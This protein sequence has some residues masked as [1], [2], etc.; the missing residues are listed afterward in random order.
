MAEA[1]AEGKGKKVVESSVTPEDVFGVIKR[2]L[3]KVGADLES[4]CE[5]VIQRILP[6]RRKSSSSSRPNSLYDA[7]GEWPILLEHIEM[8]SMKQR[9]LGR[10]HQFVACQLT[11]PT[12]CD[13]CGDFIWGL[14]KQC[15]KCKS[16]TYSL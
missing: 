6:G 14:Y 9:E 12:W 1:N 11:N 5:S 10:G 7:E 8:A 15:E 13:K 3:S 4:N 16:Y 2:K